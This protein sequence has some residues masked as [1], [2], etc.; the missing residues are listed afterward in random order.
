MICASKKCFFMAMFSYRRLFIL[1]SSQR[2]YHLTQ[3][4]K[5]KKRGAA[6]AGTPNVK[7]E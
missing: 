6:F 5:N 4:S 2:G 3:D 1:G 7:E